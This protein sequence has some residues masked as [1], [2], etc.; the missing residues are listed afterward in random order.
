MKTY[1]FRSYNF[2]MQNSRHGGVFEL[3][4]HAA[5]M[6][7]YLCLKF[8]KHVNLTF[9]RNTRLIYWYCIDHDTTA[10]HVR[11]PK[12]FRIRPPSPLCDIW[13]HRGWKCWY[14]EYLTSRICP[15]GLNLT[16]CL[17]RIHLRSVMSEADIKG[18]DRL[19]HPT[20]SVVS[21]LTARFVGPT[22]GPAGADRTQV[23]PMLAPWTLLYG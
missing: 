5:Y 2:T 11:I 4:L 22:W 20:V 15:R 1:I 6:Q 16:E 9:Q 13:Q 19:L 8:I 17:V 7:K 3:I 18:R 14:R 10:I 21:T 23:G 12:R